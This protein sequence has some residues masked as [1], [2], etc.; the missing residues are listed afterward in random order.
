MVRQP[1]DDYERIRRFIQKKGDKQFLLSDIF[2]ATD[3]S[4]G[5]IGVFLLRNFRR[6]LLEREKKNGHYLY[7]QKKNVDIPLRKSKGEV[8][9][10]VWAALVVEFPKYVT[11]QRLAILA[12]SATKTKIT[13]EHTRIVVE[14]WLK[15][16]FVDQE[17]NK[18][19]YCKKGEV[20][21]RPPAVW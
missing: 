9:Q 12:S 17:Q 6:G 7:K 11:L 14:R 15:N 3:I 18:P 1:T 2:Q 20:T 13:R 4:Q 8:A 19:L 21:E 16:G 10:A 5:V